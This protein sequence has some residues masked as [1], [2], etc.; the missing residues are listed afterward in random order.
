[1]VSGQSH[2]TREVREGQRAIRRRISD[3]ER[4]L[5]RIIYPGA[6]K[7]DL[8]PCGDIEVETSVGACRTA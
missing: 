1:M 6:F 5:I 3:D 2:R 7:N 4:G 8:I